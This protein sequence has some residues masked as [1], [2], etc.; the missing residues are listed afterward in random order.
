M[1]PLLISSFNELNQ[2]SLIGG[3]RSTVDL[4]ICRPSF[5]PPKEIIMRDD[6][7]RPVVNVKKE[8]SVTKVLN[9][10]FRDL[11]LFTREMGPN[12]SDLTSRR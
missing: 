2:H 10:F 9:D 5:V 3:H 6:S 1:E 12:R 4:D 11:N 7:G 8:K